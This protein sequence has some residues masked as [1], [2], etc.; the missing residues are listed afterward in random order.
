M[1]HIKRTQILRMLLAG[2]LLLVF[3]C[4]AN[5][6]RVPVW[7]LFTPVILLGSF[8]Y[9]ATLFIFES[10]IVRPN[11]PRM[12]ALLNALVP[13]IVLMLKSIGQ[14]TAKDL[15][16]IVL[17]VAMSAFYLSVLRFGKVPE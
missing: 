14:L 2:G 3:L 6:A 16:L 8:L 12:I 17:F 11:R 7:L 5:P 10:G 4:V 1:K 13:S 15:L 9:F